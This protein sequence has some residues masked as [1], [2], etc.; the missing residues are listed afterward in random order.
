MAAGSRLSG[1]DNT[2]VA[3]LDRFMSKA[4]NG[5]GEL[6]QLHQLLPG[7]ISFQ[8]GPGGGSYTRLYFIIYIHIYMYEK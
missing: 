5:R 8:G 2:V 3:D 6:G 7:A 1:H 4:E